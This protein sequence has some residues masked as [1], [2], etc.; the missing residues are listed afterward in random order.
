MGIQQALSE[1]VQQLVALI[2]NVAGAGFF[3]IPLLTLRWVVRFLRW[4]IS[5]ARGGPDLDEM[6]QQMWQQREHVQR[7]RSQIRSTF[8]RR[9]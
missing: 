2:F 8:K 1:L 7:V 5:L 4:G 3:L 6:E 9:Y